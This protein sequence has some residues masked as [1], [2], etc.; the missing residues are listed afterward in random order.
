[1][2]LV[3]GT[4][5]GFVTTAPVS[6]PGGSGI[7]MS[8]RSGAFKV[9]SPPGAAKITRIGFYATLIYAYAPGDISFGLYSDDGGGDPA[10]LLYSADTT[11]IT[12]S[13]DGEK[14]YLKDVDWDIEENTD[15]W[16]GF[17][18]SDGFNNPLI[19]YASSGF[20]GIKYTNAGASASIE[21]S[22]S[23]NWL[24]ADADGAFAIYALWEAA[25]TSGTN[26]YINIG[27]QLK[28]ISEM[29]IN[30]GDAW[31]NISEMYI[32]ISDVWR[33]DFTS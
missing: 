16:L 13:N 9:T 19:D 6:N 4:N 3:L 22:D 15:Y 20:D 2:A 27:D 18:I 17:F 14:W 28:Q 12:T 21:S 29:Y 7:Q 32:N 10:D 23:A 1:M 8:K 33:N 30:I 5:C 31:R 11:N 25:A 26:Q 24:N